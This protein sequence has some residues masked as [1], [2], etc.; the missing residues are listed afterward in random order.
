[1][2]ISGKAN[3]IVLMTSLVARFGGK[4]SGQYIKITSNAIRGAQQVKKNKE[5]ANNK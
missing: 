3:K 2:L 5:W 4:T 1:M